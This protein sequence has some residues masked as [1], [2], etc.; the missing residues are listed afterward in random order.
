MLRHLI[1]VLKQSSSLESKKTNLENKMAYT[2][3][4]GDIAPLAIVPD[5]SASSNGDE[6]SIPD[7][8][9][10]ID[11]GFHKKVEEFFKN[12][13]LIKSPALTKFDDLLNHHFI[14]AESHNDIGSKKFLIQN[15]KKFKEAGYDVLFIEHLYYDHQSDL[16]VFYQ[17]G[18]MPNRLKDRLK[19]LD[20]GFSRFNYRKDWDTNN[21][22]SVVVAAKKA[23]IRVVAIDTEGVYATQD[24][25][26]FATHD[27]DNRIANM[28][29]AATQIINRETSLLNNGKKWI[30]FMG[31]SHAKQEEEKI[32]GMSELTG[33]RTVFIHP[34]YRPNNFKF[35]EKQC[36]EWSDITIN[37]SLQK[38][39]E[40]FVNYDVYIRQDYQFSMDLKSL[41]NK[42]K[43]N[44]EPTKKYN[45][46]ICYD[47]AQR[48]K[49]LKK[50]ELT[51]ITLLENATESLDHEI[52]P[53]A[54]YELAC[55]Y[56]EKGKMDEGNKWMKIAAKCGHDL[57]IENLNPKPKQSIVVA[58]SMFTQKSLTKQAVM[59]TQLNQATSTEAV[60]L[61]SM[62]TPPPP[63]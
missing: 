57:A 60:Q 4:C 19:N 18:K 37:T 54:S 7:K 51:Y 20:N 63:I 44:E 8:F 50:D 13:K 62:L 61:L 39:K 21:Y 36:S 42:C 46:E 40:K 5:W 23:G 11:H 27:H 14:L 43:G 31:A 6:D 59:T 49:F 2:D 56:L 35:D 1:K 3:F 28:N 33:A 38:D 47:N 29:Y 58:N 24:C 32:P 52:T 16:D 55:Y 45:P 17:T 9:T 15:M 25:S 30:A 12:P 10:T 48:L 53:K 34:L 22:T 26:G 41:A